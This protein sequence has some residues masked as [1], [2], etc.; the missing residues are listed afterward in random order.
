MFKMSR[1]KNKYKK[2]SETEYIRTQ[3]EYINIEQE[4]N[5]FIVVEYSWSRLAWSKHKIPIIFNSIQEA[6][7]YINRYFE[8][9]K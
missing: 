3:K 5:K 8:V 7:E 9:L 4:N 6:Q 2:I 1:K